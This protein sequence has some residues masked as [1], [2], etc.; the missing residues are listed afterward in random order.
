LPLETLKS[1]S[2]VWPPKEENNFQEP[3]NHRF[4]GFKTENQNPATTAGP[5]CFENLKDPAVFNKEP[6][7][8]SR[9]DSVRVYC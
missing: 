2:P 5:T 8:V 7:F 3:E 1:L 6:G 9:V 4:R